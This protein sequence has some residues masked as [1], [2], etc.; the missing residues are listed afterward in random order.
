MLPCQ[1]RGRGFESRLPLQYLASSYGGVAK[2]LRQGSAKP[3]Y[4]GSNPPAAFLRVR[5]P[6][7]QALNPTQYHSLNDPK[8]PN[9]SLPVSVF[10]Y[11]MFKSARKRKTHIKTE[12][13]FDWI[14][15]TVYNEGEPRWRNGRRGGLKIRFL[16]KECGF[17]SLPRHQAAPKRFQHRGK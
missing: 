15:G 10:R 5:N 4:G 17:E 3:R 2:W 6:K 7:S 13:G 8:I 9:S 1:G 11:L 14:S 16:E 12:T